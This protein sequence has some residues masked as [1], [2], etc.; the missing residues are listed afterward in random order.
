MTDIVRDFASTLGA[1]D[2]SLMAELS[3]CALKDPPSGRERACRLALTLVHETV[4]DK[5]T[6]TIIQKAIR[7]LFSLRGDVM[8]HQ[9]DPRRNQSCHEAGHGSGSLWR[10]TDANTNST[11][12]GTVVNQYQAREIICKFASK[13]LSTKDLS[14]FAELLKLVLPHSPSDRERATYF[15]YVAV[16][17]TVDDE[18]TKSEIKNALRDLFLLRGDILVHHIEYIQNQ[19][20][21]DALQEL[22]TYFERSPR[23][24][25]PSGSVLVCSTATTEDSADDI[26]RAMGNNGTGVS[27]TTDFT[28]HEEQSIARVLM[29]Q[30]EEGSLQ[31][32][33]DTHSVSGCSENQDN[34]LPDSD[35]IQPEMNSEAKDESSTEAHR[36]LL[37]ENYSSS[38]SNT[39]PM[40]EKQS[41]MDR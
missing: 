4:D 38:H 7:K 23:R 1:G 26:S 11:F 2:V 5:Q 25:H 28:L 22:V 14:R 16:D 41:E 18:S 39:S 10:S 17:Q 33:S 12:D 31:R 36:G 20:R 8:E 34:S 6:K 13:F 9:L 30:T 40:D 21:H 24:R 32:S 29:K 35:F 3:K 37:Q 19:P 15:A 27:E